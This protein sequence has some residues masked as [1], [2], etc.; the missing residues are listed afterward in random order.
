MPGK[1]CVIVAFAVKGSG[2]GK[3][4]VTV[5]WSFFLSCK[6]TDLV[7]SLRGECKTVA[8]VGLIKCLEAPLSAFITIVGDKILG[9][10]T[11]KVLHEVNV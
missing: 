1:T 9:W 6:I 5:V 3:F 2:T 10:A 4:P 11:G 8:S 7:I